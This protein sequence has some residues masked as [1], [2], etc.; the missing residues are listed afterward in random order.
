MFL[1]YLRVNNALI[2]LKLMALLSAEHGTR[3][4][5]QDF[6][7]VYARFYTFRCVGSQTRAPPGADGEV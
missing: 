1:C 3:T 6:P 5:E 2:P 4:R 7:P